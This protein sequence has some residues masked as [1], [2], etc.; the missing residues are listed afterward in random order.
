MNTAHRRATALSTGLGVFARRWWRCGKANS[1]CHKERV[2]RRCPPRDRRLLDQSDASGAP[3]QGC[4]PIW[5]RTKFYPLQCRFPRI[6][7]TAMRDQISPS[8]GAKSP[9]PEFLRPKVRACPVAPVLKLSHCSPPER[10]DCCRCQP[11]RAAMDEREPLNRLM[12]K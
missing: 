12:E 3:H 1:G 8:D 5:L 9:S 2:D 6:L 10:F 4:R 7:K 11:A